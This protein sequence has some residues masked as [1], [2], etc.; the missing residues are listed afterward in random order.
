MFTQPLRL[1]SISIIIIIRYISTLFICPRGLVLPQVIRVYNLIVWISYQYLVLVCL[2]YLSSPCLQSKVWVKINEL[3]LI[4]MNVMNTNLMQ[5]CIANGW[6]L[7]NL[8]KKDVLIFEIK[9]V[10]FLI[11]G[12][13]LYVDPYSQ[14]MPSC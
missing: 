13:I 1:L 5:L 2:S 14:R 11:W 8:I 9:S 3:Y 6:R 12:T 10:L 7:N 4:D